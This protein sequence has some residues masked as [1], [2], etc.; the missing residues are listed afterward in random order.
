MRLLKKQ[1]NLKFTS[2]QSQTSKI[3]LFGML[4]FNSKKQSPIERGPTIITMI[5]INAYTRG[6]KNMFLSGNLGNRE[7]ISAG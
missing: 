7:K 1:N 6:A 5:I 2:V 4:C 3:Y